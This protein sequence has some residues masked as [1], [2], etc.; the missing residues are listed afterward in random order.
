MLE[1]RGFLQTLG[2]ATLAGLVRPEAAEAMAAAPPGMI[3]RSL[4][5]DAPPLPSDS[6]FQTSPETY[7]AELRRQW[8]FRPGFI[9]LNN[10]TCGSCPLPVVRA[11]IESILKEEQME[12]DETE[13]YPLW[14]YGPWDQYRQPMAEFIGAG[15][16]ELALVRNATEGLNYVANGIDLNRGD[17]VLITDEE[18]PSGLSPWLLK[19]K[20]YGTVVKQ[21]AMPKPPKSQ[22]QILDLLDAGRTER[23]LGGDGQ[24]RQ[25]GHGLRDA[26]E[27][28]LRVGPA[29]W[30]SDDGG[31]RA[32]GGDDSDQHERHRLRF[33][34]LQPAQV[35]AGA[36]GHR[37]ALCPRR[38]R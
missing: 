31:R 32:H 21:V 11:F 3:E 2:A 10:G 22:Q 14:G 1:R 38:S 4:C 33:L 27:G 28:D 8:L 5:P 23:T 35:A 29:A 37:A 15:L 16:H 19:A 12:N 34:H 6:L 13:Q 36:Q 24:P 30:P 18:H 17:E 7:W 25:L 20:R 26:G 9:Y